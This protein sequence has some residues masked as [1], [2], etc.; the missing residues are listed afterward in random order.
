[1]TVPLNIVPTGL[2]KP[3]DCDQA[4]FCY[5]RRIKWSLLQYI[6]ENMN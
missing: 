4:V 3:K 2:C 5:G 6:K 1:M